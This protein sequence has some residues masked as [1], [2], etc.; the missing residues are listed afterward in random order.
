MVQHEATFINSRAKNKITK[1]DQKIIRADVVGRNK[2]KITL[3]NEIPVPKPIIY[4][5]LADFHKDWRLD[6]TYHSE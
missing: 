6:K 1:G 4:A 3:L 5:T 2:I